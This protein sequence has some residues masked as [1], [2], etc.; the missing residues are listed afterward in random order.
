MYHL[1]L[2]R[3]HKSLGLNQPHFL[4]Q[5][6]GAKINAVGGQMVNSSCK[7][8]WHNVYHQASSLVDITPERL[9]RRW[10]DL[11]LTDLRYTAGHAEYSDAA[12]DPMF[13]NNK[14]KC[15]GDQIWQVPASGWLPSVRFY[16]DI[17]LPSQCFLINCQPCESQSTGVAE[18][19]GVR[20]FVCICPGLV[21]GFLPF[22]F[23]P[24]S[25]HQETFVLIAV[26]CF[27]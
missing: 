10:G 8:I 9:T 27:C 17:H 19:P 20:V 7:T 16:V 1:G 3:V 6:A 22:C 12:S 23:R 26:S 14:N 18:R 21:D 25:F 11:I 13:I 4:T 15:L 24:F 2:Q 5:T